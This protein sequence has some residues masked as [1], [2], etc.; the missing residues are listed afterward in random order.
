MKPHWWTCFV[1]SGPTDGGT[2][3]LKLGFKLAHGIL[4]Q[5]SKA[6]TFAFR[7]DEPC[8]SSM[9]CV[10]PWLTAQHK[11]MLGGT[12]TED[13]NWLVWTC[14]LTRNRNG[15]F[16]TNHDLRVMTNHFYFGSEG[17]SRDT[18]YMIAFVVV[19]WLESNH[20]ELLKLLIFCCSPNPTST[21]DLLIERT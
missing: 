9:D 4:I 12:G 2:L 5:Q 8:F 13:T 6:H 3:L 15:F 1:N 11:T 18:F 10:A 19:E 14:L 17:D 16:M 7:L 20:F 21:K